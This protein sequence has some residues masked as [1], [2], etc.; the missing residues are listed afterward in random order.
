MFGADSGVPEEIY[1]SVIVMRHRL[2]EVLAEKVEADEIDEDYG[3]KIGSQ[4]LRENALK[5]FP[6]LRSRR[7]K[8]PPA[9]RR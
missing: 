7:W 3:L 5:L 8:R 9:A 6:Q 2:A 4:I 1:A